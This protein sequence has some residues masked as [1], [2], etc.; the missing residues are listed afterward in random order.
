MPVSIKGSGGGSVTLDAS[1]ASSD[2]TLTLPNTNGTVINT[3]P[4]TSGNVLTS[5]GTAWTSAAS[6]VSNGSVT[7]AKLSTGGPSWDSSGNLSFNSGY[8]STAVAYACR[9]W[10]NW[11][12]STGTIRGSGGVT[13]VTRNT[14]GDYT[15]NFSFT[16]PDANYNATMMSSK[17]ALASGSSGLIC[18]A[19]NNAPTTTTLRVYNNP[20]NSGGSSTD[21][22]YTCVS[23]FR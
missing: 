13:S 21:N 2:T 7:P 6:T 16:M 12:G 22:V 10:A 20:S 4:G 9:A 3:A 18:I 8:G 14:T 5:N 23:I 15:I 11:A 1:T 19:E 17:S